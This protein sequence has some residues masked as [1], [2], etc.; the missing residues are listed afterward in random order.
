MYLIQIILIVS[1]QLHSLFLVFQLLLNIIP[2][3]IFKSLLYKKLSLQFPVFNLG[4]DTTK[5]DT[6]RRGDMRW[7]HCD[8]RYGLWPRRAQNKIQVTACY[9]IMLLVCDILA[10]VGANGHWSRS[11]LFFFIYIPVR[12]V[13]IPS[14]AQNCLYLGIRN[15]QFC[16]DVNYCD[17]FWK[18]YLVN[19]KTVTNYLPWDLVVSY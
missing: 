18:H 9:S 15:H 17:L 14:N 12:D 5:L 10:I 11:F 4:F 1:Y 2:G 6:S 16:H 7:R 13:Y 3:F 19:F 8:T